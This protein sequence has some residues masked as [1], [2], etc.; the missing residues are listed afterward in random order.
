M[1][2]AP[3]GFFGQSQYT[4]LYTTTIV[5]KHNSY[6]QN[7]FRREGAR[8]LLYLGWADNWGQHF[9]GGQAPSLRVL[10]NTYKHICSICKITIVVVYNNIN[11][12]VPFVVA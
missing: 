10:K 1:L 6:K 2:P 12:H 11:R 3:C 7:D 8:P 4:H 5:T 9:R